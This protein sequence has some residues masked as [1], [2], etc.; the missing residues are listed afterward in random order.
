[1]SQFK[2]YN[3]LAYLKLLRKTH[4][5]IV[6]KEFIHAINMN[7]HIDTNIVS[8]L[9]IAFIAVYRYATSFAMSEFP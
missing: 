1:M 5:K 2:H 3:D 7:V 9:N 8:L 6:N 4:R